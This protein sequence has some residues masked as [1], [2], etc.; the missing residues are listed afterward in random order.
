MPIPPG[1]RENG[2]QYS[3]AAAWLG[4]ALAQ[5]GDADGAL[6]AFHM[7]CPVHRAA[8]QEGAELYRIEPYVVPGDIAAA[9]PHRGKGG[10]SW[11]T[12]AASWA[13]R[14]GVEGLLGLTMHDGSVCIAPSL[15]T[16]W[17]GYSAT[18]RRG[19][20]RIAVQ[21]ERSQDSLDTH[22][23][24]DGVPLA[25]EAIAFPAEGE[26]RNVLVRIGQ[27]TLTRAGAPA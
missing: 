16:D 7:I 25:R 23:E 17:P 21:V 8:T 13:W 4:L 10:W 26:T 20:A 24:V 5:T 22:V 19:N 1:L 11:Y 12:G 15:P 3:H 14:L 18:L 6:D 2:G 27:K 9:E